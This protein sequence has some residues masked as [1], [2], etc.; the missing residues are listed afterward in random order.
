M[1][2]LQYVCCRRAVTMEGFR[3]IYLAIQI[4]SDGVLCGLGWPS[5]DGFPIDSIFY[6]LLLSSE[7]DE[8]YKHE[9]RIYRQ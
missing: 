6:T 2:D 9:Q 1:T 4:V 5:C 8:G 3:C 7:I